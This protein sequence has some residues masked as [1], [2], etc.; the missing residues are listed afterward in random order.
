MAD[1]KRTRSRKK[2]SRDCLRFPEVKGKI[3]E[4]V[5]VDPEAEAI[6]IL[7]QDK[8]VLSFDVDPRCVVFPEFS[9]WKTG[10]WKG[11]KRWPPVQS[12]GSMVR[13]P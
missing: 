3:I 12:R 5:E 2:H 7:F 8:T 9:D 6:V 10:N 11:I 4:Q 1:Q 13:W